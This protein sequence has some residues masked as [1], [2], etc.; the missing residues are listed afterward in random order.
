MT[1]EQIVDQ[2]LVSH[3]EEHLSQARAAIAALQ[4]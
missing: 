3:V 1:V 2:F 4:V